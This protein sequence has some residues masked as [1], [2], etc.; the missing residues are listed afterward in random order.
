[1]CVAHLGL[2]MPLLGLPA[3]I[4]EYLLQPCNPIHERRIMLMF[5]GI[6]LRVVRLEVSAWISKTI[7]KR[8]YGFLS[9]FPP[10]SFTE[11]VR[12]CV[13]VKK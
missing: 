5:L 13:S 9:G 7:G 11:T 12:G 8:V 10:F 3:H 4:T 2:V 1:M 6:I